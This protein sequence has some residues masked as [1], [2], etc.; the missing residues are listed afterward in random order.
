[1]EFFL[2]NM[3]AN[4][5]MYCVKLVMSPVWLETVEKNVVQLIEGIPPKQRILE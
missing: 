4:R 1:M 3:N 2:P 5:N